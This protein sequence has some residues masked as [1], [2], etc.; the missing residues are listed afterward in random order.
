MPRYVVAREFPNGLEIPINNAGAEAML[1]V[2]ERNLT[3][4]VS[5]VHSYVSADRK[6][7]FCIYD[8]PTPDAIRRAGARNELPVGAIT[9]VSVLT[10]Y[11]YKGDER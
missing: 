1:A 3:E 2:V 4:K 9:E 11:F 7:T 6:R 10:P 8:A 5:W